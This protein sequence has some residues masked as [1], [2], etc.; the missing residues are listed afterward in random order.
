ML[1]SSEF[2]VYLLQ[3]KNLTEGVESFSYVFGF[4]FES[5]QCE[6]SQVKKKNGENCLNSTVYC[7]ECMMEV[8]DSKC[9]SVCH[10]SETKN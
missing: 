3:L 9:L 8:S 4:G 6:V 7:S 2:W 10:K 1:L 5:L